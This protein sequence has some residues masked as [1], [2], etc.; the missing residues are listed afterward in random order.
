MGN[1]LVTLLLCLLGVLR[2]Y[3]VDLCR[4]LQVLPLLHQGLASVVGAEGALEVVG[5]LVPRN[6][7]G[8]IIKSYLLRLVLLLA[9]GLVL[10]KEGVL[11]DR[12]VIHGAP[13]LGRL[14]VAPV[15]RDVLVDALVEA[16]GHLVHVLVE[17]LLLLGKPSATV[18]GEHL[19]REGLLAS[20]SSLG[21]PDSVVHLN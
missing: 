5:E 2:I 1:A 18:H 10:L 20:A 7:A 21:V 11:H 4:L 3:N 16:L 8:H 19:L 12:W 15:R 13:T 6:W 9:F 17:V 14:V